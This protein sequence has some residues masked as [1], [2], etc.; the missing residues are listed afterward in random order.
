MSDHNEIV[1]AAKDWAGVKNDKDREATRSRN[2]PTNLGVA[3]G[4]GIGSAALA[5]VLLYAREGRKKER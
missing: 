4:V 2:W 1:E 3:A 5:A